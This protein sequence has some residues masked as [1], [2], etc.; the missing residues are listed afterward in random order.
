MY[1]RYIRDPQAV[2]EEAEALKQFLPPARRPRNTTRMRRRSS[3]SMEK[4][5][6]AV[7]EHWSTG[8]GRRLRQIVWSIYNGRALV[9]LGDVLTNFDGELCEAVAT[10]NHA[11]LCSVDMDDL[12]REVLKRSGEFFRYEEAERKTPEDEE[13][14]Y[15]PIQVSAERL[16]RLADS[17]ARL[18]TALKRGVRRKWPLTPR[19]TI[20]D[21]RYPSSRYEDIQ[22][23]RWPL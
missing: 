20:N 8:S 6:A 19:K 17:A 3:A 9:N 11:K 15:P 7:T 18:K 10:L 22:L 12:L 14:L 23:L 4:I 5:T 21:G 13:V 2:E 16:R 1:G